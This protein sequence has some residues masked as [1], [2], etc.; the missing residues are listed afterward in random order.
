M[1][2]SCRLNRVK[3]HLTILLG[4]DISIGIP[5]CNLSILFFK[6]CIQCVELVLSPGSETLLELVFQATKGVVFGFSKVPSLHHFDDELISSLYDIIFIS[7]IPNGFF[8]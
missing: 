4:N 7:G 1:H 8:V 3:T 5:P 6:D 2:N